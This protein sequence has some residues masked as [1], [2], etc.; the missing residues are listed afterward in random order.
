MKQDEIWYCENS[1]GHKIAPYGT[2]EDVTK[3]K[4]CI[5]IRY[6]YNAILIWIAAL[7]TVA[8]IMMTL[9]S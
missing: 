4:K 5:N 8:I 3:S 9:M 2:Y 1:K 6:P 7:G